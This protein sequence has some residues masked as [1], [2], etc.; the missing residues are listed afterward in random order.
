[1]SSKS[2]TSVYHGQESSKPKHYYTSHPPTTHSSDHQH[3]Q[4]YRLSRY[5]QDTHSTPMASS[6]SPAHI[7]AA[8]QTRIGNQTDAILSRFY[9]R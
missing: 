9:Q 8:H 4:S 5:G 6:Q 3:L 7:E 1:M 2:N